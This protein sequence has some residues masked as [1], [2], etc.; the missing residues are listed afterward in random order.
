MPDF[1]DINQSIIDLIGSK[2]IIMKKVYMIHG[3][4]ETSG[5]NWFPWLRKELE[6]RGFEVIALQMP[7]ADLPHIEKWVPALKN[8]VK[9]PDESTYFVGHS[10]GCQ[11]IIRYLETLPR[12]TRIGGAVFVAGFL[13]HITNL[14]QEPDVLDVDREWAETPIDFA[15]ARSHLSKSVAIFSTND[16]CVS[17]D[18]RED[19][20]QKLGSEIITL[21]NKDHLDADDNAFKLPEVLEA[22]LKM[23]GTGE[24]RRGFC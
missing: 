22:V 15:K 12:E 20:Q 19:F 6:S 11:A 1:L 4:D 24:G 21:Q 17:F 9:D 16:P 3:W 2:I 8:I 10:M 7:D 13:R 18:N 14:E 5:E 23:T